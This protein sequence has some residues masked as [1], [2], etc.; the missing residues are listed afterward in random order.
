MKRQ[1]MSGQF[2]LNLAVPSASAQCFI[3]PDLIKEINQ[4]YSAQV[5]VEPSDF[6][7]MGEP[8]RRVVVTSTSVDCNTLA[9]QRVSQII[10]HYDKGGRTT[11]NSLSLRVLV[12]NQYAGLIIGKGGTTIRE[13]QSQSLGAKIQLAKKEEMPPN[14]MESERCVTLVGSLEQVTKAQDLMTKKLESFK[15]LQSSSRF[16]PQT[17]PNTMYQ[18]PSMPQHQQ[19][20]YQNQ[21]FRGHMQHQPQP[22]SMPS[23]QSQ[24][25]HH[26]QHRQHHQRQQPQHQ[27]QHT[28]MH[29]HPH[30]ASYDEYATQPGKLTLVIPDNHMGIVVG[31][32]GSNLKAAIEQCQNSVRIQQEKVENTVASQM[33]GQSM[34]SINLTGPIAM[35]HKAAGLLLARIQTHI[36]N[37][38]C[39]EWT[40]IFY[41]SVNPDA[42]PVPMQQSGSHNYAR[43]FQPHS[44]GS[45]Y[46]NNQQGRFR[47]DYQR[48]QPH[49]S[50]QGHRPPTYEKQRYSERPVDA[51]RHD[52][53]RPPPPPLDG[54][55]KAESQALDGE[56]TESRK[57]QDRDAKPEAENQDVSDG[58]EDE[59]GA[60]GIKRKFVT[61]EG[62]VEGSE[63]RPEKRT[64][65]ADTEHKDEAR[66][67]AAVGEAE[68]KTEG[69]EP[70]K[71]KDTG[72]EETVDDEADADESKPTV[73]EVEK[74][75][76]VQL[77]QVLTERGLDTSGL[78]AELL[79]RVKE[80]LYDK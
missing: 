47:N 34:R 36:T 68:T 32:G 75:T 31:K 43:N 58:D 28:Q 16:V 67:K 33:I 80:A 49:G 37:K 11:G 9:Q 53:E 18:K 44:Q 41:P 64:V 69:N 24:Q 57:V 30:T 56:S 63:E 40:S 13:L 61:D 14:M 73:D 42:P 79:K 59:A 54:P 48:R 20:M 72:E 60:R 10:D 22:P 76:K 77:K 74:M 7:L 71:E 17:R 27:P 66:E 29:M 38:R 62:D 45:R 3:T 50:P 1:K 5:Q 2:V 39:S 12:E 23:Y 46:G 6:H 51:E 78:K 65:S 55:V 21:Q 4:Y 19:P 15:E 25:H 52:P 70:S 35:T 8:V 26:H